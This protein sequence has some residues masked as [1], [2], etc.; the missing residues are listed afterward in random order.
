MELTLFFRDSQCICFT[1][2]ID[3]GIDMTV[4][5]EKCT[6]LGSHHCMG[7]FSLT[8]DTTEPSFNW[9]NHSPISQFSYKN[10]G[11]KFKQYF[12]GDLF[13]CH[14]KSNSVS[15]NHNYSYCYG[16]AAATC[17]TDATATTAIIILPIF[18]QCP[19]ID[20]WLLL[21]FP[22]SL[23]STLSPRLQHHWWGRQQHRRQRVCQR[24]CRLLLSPWIPAG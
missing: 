20:K 5:S 13:T 2:D 22:A 15:V 24:L 6:Q 1:G 18:A 19:R 10:L 17:V 11:S 9:S 21:D 3:I 8:P 16:C 12:F 14:F 23:Q 7:I 4:F